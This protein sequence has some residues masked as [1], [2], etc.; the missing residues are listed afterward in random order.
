MP[1]ES[2]YPYAENDN[3][4][5]AECDEAAVKVSVTDYGYVGGFYGAGC[6]ENIM[7]EI[8]ARGPIVGNFAPPFDFSYYKS[9]IFH[10]VAYYELEDG[11]PST[12]TIRA[13]GEVWEKVDHSIVIIGW[14]EEDGDKYWIC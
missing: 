8:Y 1:E 6:E 9:G 13:N 3:V 2:C 7:K 4:C 11:D 14:G 10:E 5:N 12:R